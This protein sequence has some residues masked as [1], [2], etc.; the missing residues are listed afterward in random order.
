V[1]EALPW[2]RGVYRRRI[3]LVADPSGVSGDAAAHGLVVGDLEDDFHRFR[4]VLEHDGARVLGA[5]G[6]AVRFPW[7]TCAEAPGVLSALRGAPLD[8]RCTSV[9]RQADP[10]SQCTHL[11]DLAGLAL[12]HAAAGR[13]RRDYEA[14]VPD[15]KDGPVEAR[16]WLDGREA[17]VFRVDLARILEPAPF[18]GRSLH[19]GSFLRW[20]RDALAPEAAESAFVLWRACA[21]AL[22]RAFPVDRVPDP[23]M[24]LDRT[25]GSCFTFGPEVVPRARRAPGTRRDFT[26][27]RERLLAPEREGPE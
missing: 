6:E 11:F 2:G 15:R 13:E 16:L 27:A 9:A 21:I 25:A 18:E 19:G 26:D 1:S 22:G 14:E 12:A 17:L 8:V 5:R 3:R 10:R 24:F 20:C 4:V 23:T 7:T